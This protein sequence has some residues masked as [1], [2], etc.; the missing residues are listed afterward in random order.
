M[1]ENFK[2]TNCGI[3]FVEYPVSIDSVGIGADN[4]YLIP[5]RADN[6]ILK[7]FAPAMTREYAN[8]TALNHYAWVNVDDREGI[9]RWEE[10]NYLLAMANPRL[11]VALKVKKS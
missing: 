3:T 4:A 6:F 8:T 11:K 10:S 9:T 7:G 2:S 5:V 1:V